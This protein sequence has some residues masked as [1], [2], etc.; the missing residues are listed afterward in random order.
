MPD[1]REIWVA[2]SETDP[3]E[4]GVIPEPFIW[5]V[6]HGYD[7]TAYYEFSDT[8]AFVDFVSDKDIILYAHNGGK[9]D[10]HFISHRFE[11]DSDLLIISGRLARFKIGKCEFRDS[12]SLMPVSLEQYNKMKFDYTK[13]HKS[14]RHLYMDEIREYLE[15]DCINLWRMVYGFDN[16]YGRH[17]TQATAAMKYWQNKLK[18]KIP[19]SDSDFYDFIKP[20]YYGGR[21]QCFAQG[22]YKI[23]ALS[24]DINSAYPFAMLSD[25]PYSVEHE[26][27]PGKPRKKLENW[28]PLLFTIEANS[29]GAFPYRGTNKKL[30]FP[31]DGEVRTYTITGWELIAALET[32]TVDNIK[33]IEYIEFEETKNFSEYV[34]H[35]WNER[36]RFKSEGDKGGEFYCKIFLNSLYGKFGMDIR[37]HKNYTLKPRNHLE[38][39]T[40]ELADGET[41]QHFKEWIIHCEQAKQGKKRF[42][43]LAT[44]AS[45][46]GFVRAMLWRTI[47][48]ATGP[49]YC[50]TDSITAEAFA[51]TLPITKELG[52]WGIEYYYD[53]VI[54]CGKKLY[55]MHSKHD[56]CNGNNCK[57]RA[58][59]KM[60]SKGA[61]L[62]F[63]DLIKI[64]AGE[65]VQY[66]NIV[67]TFSMSKEKPTFVS[68]EIK[69][70]ASDI[71]IVPRRFDPKYET[72][73]TDETGTD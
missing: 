65:K 68:R 42:Y 56:D 2:D 69:A 25:H 34:N 19:R 20:F 52:D 66:N 22:D 71:R 27:K 48:E 61:R 67:P 43:N 32:E 53:R 58:H 60:A 40:H 8:D 64:A 31:D 28:G 9:F 41:I 6:Y 29:K 12:F 39:A 3:F 33:F 21:V 70:T 54:V 73:V 14:Q 23:D 13:M 15:S 26:I 51:E 38:Q 5:G 17:I 24:V 37:K 1:D 4:L 18:N 10:W 59:W 62:E 46:T 7:N 44:A 36:Q 11:P 30:Y 35:F 72:S 16:T 55:A 63:D 50:D 47:C 45:I 49:M 57:T